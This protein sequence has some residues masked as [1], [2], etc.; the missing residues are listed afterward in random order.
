[1]VSRSFAELLLLYP[2]F[3]DYLERLLIDGGNY[4]FHIRGGRL[5][6]VEAKRSEVKLREHMPEA[7]SQAMALSEITGCDALLFIAL[8]L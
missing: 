7:V 5:C 2:L 8:H 1:V 3:Y 6:L 4:A